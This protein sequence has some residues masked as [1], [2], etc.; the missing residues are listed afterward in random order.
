[1]RAPFPDA[2]T[3]PLNPR[4]STPWIFLFSEFR[5]AFGREIRIKEKDR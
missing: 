3:V 5:D 1:M 2:R 4:L